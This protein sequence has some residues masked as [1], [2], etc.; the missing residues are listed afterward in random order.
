VHDG[1]VR[2][3]FAHLGGLHRRALVGHQRPRLAALVNRL[4]RATISALCERTVSS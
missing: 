1:E 2:E 3:S 4:L